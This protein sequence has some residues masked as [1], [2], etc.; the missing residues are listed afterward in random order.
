M[1]SVP[2]V[3]PPPLPYKHCKTN[4]RL[5]N[6]GTWTPPLFLPPPPHTVKRRVI[7]PLNKYLEQ[8]CTLRRGLVVAG[9]GEGEREDPF[10]RTL[11]L[12]WLKNRPSNLQ[13]PEKPNSRRESSRL[14]PPSQENPRSLWPKKQL[15]PGRRA[16]AGSRLCLCC[17][18]PLPLPRPQIRMETNAAMRW[19]GGGGGRESS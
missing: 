4:G 18:P 8:Q 1:S 3:P 19:A 13:K 17:S 5:T 7:S 10:A 15:S 9:G 11:Q 14:P 6:L 2:V 12:S 16:E